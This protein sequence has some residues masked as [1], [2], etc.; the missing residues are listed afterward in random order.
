[1]EQFILNPIGTIR[2]REGDV[3]IELDR[4]YIPA[5]AVLDGFSHVNVLWWC[6]G[7]DT[8]ELRS[9]L[10]APSPYKGSPEVMGIFATRSPMRPNPIALT[11]AQI[12]GID[13]QNGVIRLSYIDADDKTPVIDL[14]PYTPSLDRIEFPLVPDWCGTWPKSLEESA[15]FDWDDVFN[16]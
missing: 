14:K 12:I 11:A 9:I 10:E 5:L 4:E 6:S 7:C 3:S 2:N 8:A 15:N 13:H 1:M 16:F